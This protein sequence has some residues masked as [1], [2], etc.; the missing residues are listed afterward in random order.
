M[1]IRIVHPSARIFMGVIFE[2]E[3]QKIWQLFVSGE[4]DSLDITGKIMPQMRDQIGINRA[5][6]I[7]EQP[8][9]QDRHL[10]ISMTKIKLWAHRILLSHFKWQDML[11]EI[12]MVLC[13][14]MKLLHP[15]DGMMLFSRKI[16]LF[17][18]FPISRMD[19]YIWMSS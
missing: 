9:L 6:A 7:S 2:K 19:M 15:I 14:P 1:R 12:R 8:I 3:M 5:I 17:H 10:L 16:V 11:H 13:E 18:S 4:T